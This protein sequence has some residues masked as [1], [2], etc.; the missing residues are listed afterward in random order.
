M[1]AALG[2]GGGYPLDPVRSALVLHAAPDAFPLDQEGHLVEAAH[3]RGVGPQDLELPARALGVAGVHLEQVLG[4]EV[5]LLA[6]LGAPDLHDH[7][8][9]V[10]GVAGQQQHPQLVGQPGHGRLGVVDLGP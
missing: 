10:V 5:G 2:L 9:V 6:P 1:D 7:V 4:E 8:L 3:G